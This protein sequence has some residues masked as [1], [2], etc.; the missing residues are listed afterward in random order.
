MNGTPVRPSI[1]KSE[2][3]VGSIITQELDTIFPEDGFVQPDGRATLPGRSASSIEDLLVNPLEFPKTRSAFGKIRIFLSCVSP[4]SLLVYE[5]QVIVGRG[6]GARH[7][8]AVHNKDPF[9]VG[10]FGAWVY[11]A[12]GGAIEK[13]QRV[14]WLLGQIV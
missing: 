2:Q 12:G 8:F 7:G 14:K 3:S 9:S 11:K 10:Q 6:L 4:D 1:H 13:G 5:W